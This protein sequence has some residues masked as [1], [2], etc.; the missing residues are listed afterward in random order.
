[1]MRMSKKECVERLNIKY[2]N[3][4]DYSETEFNGLK[5]LI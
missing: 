5:L 1:M 2:N 3:F 4:Y